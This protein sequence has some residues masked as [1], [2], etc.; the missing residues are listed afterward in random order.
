MF[1]CLFCLDRATTP[2]HSGKWE[3][4]PSS[5]FE[6]DIHSSLLVW[7]VSFV[8][9]RSTFNSFVRLLERTNS[10]QPKKKTTTTM[11]VRSRTL[12]YWPILFSFLFSFTH[13]SVVCPSVRSPAD[14]V[15]A[16]LVVIATLAYFS[17]VLH[18]FHFPQT[19]AAVVVT[20]QQQCE[21]DWLHF[22]QHDF[23]HFQFQFYRYVI[24]SSWNFSQFYSIKSSTGHWSVLKSL[25][26]MT[27]FPGFLPNIAS[28][29]LQ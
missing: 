12:R 29:W 6:K 1:S 2:R 11:R 28:C 21:G 5:L 22:H 20:V 23:P 18:H 25:V 15:L 27:P 7:S 3:K 8:I 24:Q 4:I 10:K 19:A 17:A 26:G 13:P 9:V 16:P 14:R